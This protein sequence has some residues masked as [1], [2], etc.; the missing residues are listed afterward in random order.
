MREVKDI[1]YLVSCFTLKSQI[2]VIF[3]VLWMV[4]DQFI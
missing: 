4:V 3:S 1:F 2:E